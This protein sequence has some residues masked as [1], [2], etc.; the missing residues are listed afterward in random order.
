MGYLLDGLKSMWT[1]ALNAIRP[2][3]TQEFPKVLR[4]HPE[5]YHTSFALLHDETG[6]EACT[7]CGAC[8]RIC[9]SQVITVKLGKRESAI[10]QKKRG[11]ADDFTLDLTACLVC[12]LCV[13]VCPTDAIVM[14]K[15]PELPGFRREDLV[16]SMPRLY[17]N[18]KSKPLGWSNATKLM[19]MQDPKAG[20]AKPE[21]S[22]ETAPAPAAAGAAS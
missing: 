15:V 6:D 14:L 20:A 10:T 7:G 19:A 5:R 17:E 11:Y 8:A 3:F 12:E 18:E 2:P 22:K 13:Q 9:P 1:T 4:P 16:L 21:P